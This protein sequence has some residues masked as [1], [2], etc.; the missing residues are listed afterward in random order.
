MF[1]SLK[2]LSSDEVEN[3][4]FSLLSGLIQDQTLRT[5]LQPYTLEGSYGD[6]FD[7]DDESIE[8]DN[9]LAFEMNDIMKR[10]KEAVIPALEY[11]FHLLEGRFNGDPTLLIMDEAWLF[12]K[13][14]RFSDKFDEWLKTLRKLDVFVV[15]AT[16][17][18]EDA[19]KS[20]AF[21]AILNSVATRIYLPNANVGAKEMA[22]V[23]KKMDLTDEDLEMIRHGRRKRDYFVVQGINRSMVDL[24]LGDI[25]LALT[26]LSGSKDHAMLDQIE[27]ERLS[28]DNVSP[29]YAA[30]QILRRKALVWA[31]EI[32]EKLPKSNR[33]L[34][35]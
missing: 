13:D 35:I 30:E 18:I 2:S 11:L 20:D 27:Q 10:G 25:A 28:H 26:T 21:H 15:F 23:Y 9:I 12:L 7:A 34:E 1:E 16:T 8:N 31:A 4:T 29:T 22:K 6:I 24:N 3:R 33:Y 14:S 32:L 5:A 17:E 19:V